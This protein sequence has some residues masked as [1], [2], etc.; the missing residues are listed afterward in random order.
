MVWVLQTF[1]DYKSWNNFTKSKLQFQ[2]LNRQEVESLFEKR[3]NW[4]LFSRL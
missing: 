2:I 3:N 4:K 1:E